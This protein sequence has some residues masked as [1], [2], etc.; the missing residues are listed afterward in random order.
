MVWPSFG[1]VMIE[2]NIAYNEHGDMLV[3][4]DDI[5][6]LGLMDV[7]R[8][9]KI[10]SLGY[11]LDEDGIETYED[12]QRVSKALQT[13][14]REVSPSRVAL[15]GIVFLLLIGVLMSG[16]YWALP[17]DAVNVE[18]KYLQRGGHLIMS[19]IHN[20][21]SRDITDVSV[22]VEFRSLEGELLE[23]MYIEVDRIESHSSVAGDNLEMM[24]LGYS[25]WDEYTIKIE[26]KYTNHGGNEVIETW[27]HSVGYWS[28]EWFIDKAERTT[29]PNS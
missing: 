20:T 15:A 27:S 25:V 11:T 10:E 19:E 4:E 22:E 13:I 29:W 2:D 3:H 23:F 21:G 24:V 12:M 1:D 16:W 14:R 8:L 6:S 17:R 26:L 18:T 5:E 28:T 7:A 9:Q